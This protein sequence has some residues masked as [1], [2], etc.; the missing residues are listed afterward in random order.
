MRTTPEAAPS[1]ASAMP[2]DDAPTAAGAR[3]G[4]FYE[5]IYPREALDAALAV[6]GLQDDI[7]ALRAELH[8]RLGAE[9][10]EK[11][12][13]I[14]RCFVA[15]VRAVGVAHGLRKTEREAFDAR[16]RET[17]ATFAR[18]LTRELRERARGE[19]DDEDGDDV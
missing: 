11:L 13:D 3:R 1:E 7:A 17:L 18:S 9:R 2:G 5:G 19:D 14:I 8:R 4:N 15:L 6:E 12:A 16:A 10:P